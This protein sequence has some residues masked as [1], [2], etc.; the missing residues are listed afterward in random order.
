MG[1]KFKR[2]N[3]FYVDEAGHIN[4]DSTV[5]IHGCIKTDVPDVITDAL[6]NLHED[7]IENLY[8]DEDED[9]IIKEGFHAVENHPDVRA[10]FY[11]LLPLLDYRAYF[12]VVDKKSNFFKNLK[13]TKEDH[14]IFHYFLNKLLRDRLQKNKHDKNIFFFEDLEIEKKSLK[15]ILQ[16]IKD[17]LPP[18]YDCEFH[19][20]GKELIN[21]AVVDYLNYVLYSILSTPKSN[22]RMEKN[23]N[24]IAPK[25]GVI[26]IM[27]KNVYLSRK[28]DDTLKVTLDNLKKEFSG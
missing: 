15:Q 3:Y 7:I 6:E 1:S 10:K 2:T 4:N 20:R 9:R 21:L 27:H 12:T 22:D 11:M 24:L 28:N 8:F 23:F 17:S 18:S 16:D 19:I 13:S 14:E 5:F 26:N 25:I